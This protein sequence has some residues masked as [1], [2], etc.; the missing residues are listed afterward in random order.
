L[1]QKLRE[2]KDVE[3]MDPEIEAAIDKPVQIG[4]P[5]RETQ[6]DYAYSFEA[7]MV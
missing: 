2:A 5:L 4:M 6:G 7:N 1:L 3:V